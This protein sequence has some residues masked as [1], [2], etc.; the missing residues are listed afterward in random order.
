MKINKYLTDKKADGLSSK[1]L[2]YS[3]IAAAF[4]AT[5]PDV[6]SQCAGES[7][8]PAPGGATI[9]V[10]IDGDG[11]DDVILFAGSTSYLANYGT[12]STGV[13][14]IP[15]GTVPFATAMATATFPGTA[16]PGYPFYGCNLFSGTAGPAAGPATINIPALAATATATVSAAVTFTNAFYITYYATYVNI[17]Y[18]FVTAAGANQIVGL[19]GTGSGV[20]SLI[21]STAGVSGVG[22]SS[23]VGYNADVL[24]I[25]TPILV[26]GINYDLPSSTVTA[27]ATDTFAY[28]PAPSCTTAT[29][30]IYGGYFAGIQFTASTV[31][32]ASVLPIADANY[33]GPYLLSG[34]SYGQYAFPTAT[35]N[36]ITHVA[37]QF[38]VAGETHNG[39]VAL[40]FG[41]DGSLTC[42]GSGY[43]QCSIET[44]VENAT[45][46]DAC[47]AVGDATNESAACAPSTD[48]PTLSEWGLITLAL[49]L[50]SYGSIAMTA[51]GAGMAGSN[52]TFNFGS[53]IFSLPFDNKVYRKA[54]M[55][56]GLLAIAGFTGCFALYGAIFMTDI[57]GVAIAG[58]IFAYLSHLLYLLEARK[59]K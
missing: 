24:Q 36:P 11:T 47:I 4:V 38:D 16:I 7:V 25:Y 6:N 27:M 18:A 40:T 15:A 56:T 39:W 17:N 35:A 21:D 23:F 30:S 33:P 5:S 9:G 53:K 32:T 10:D 20:C 8:A 55:L 29:A 52:Q 45:A 26:G 28:G 57:I 50:M 1:L 49:L 51:T 44:A 31:A 41:A 58:P 59:E 42:A 34:P 48:I 37:V 2:S 46:S 22:T 3:A 13:G 43:Q 19:P 12:T 54:L 14:S